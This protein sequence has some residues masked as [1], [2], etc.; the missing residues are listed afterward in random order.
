[1]L[2]T[3][4]LV[5]PS[6]SQ[7]DVEMSSPFFMEGRLY[8]ACFAFD[9]SLPRN[10]Q[11][12]VL[13]CLDAE[14]GRILWRELVC[15]G[16][17]SS[18]LGF[19]RDGKPHVSIAARRG[20]LQCYDVSGESPRRAWSFQMPH[21]TL[22]SPVVADCDGRTLLF[23][24]SKYG[25]LIALDAATGKEVWQK[26]AGNWFDN[27]ACVGDVGGRKLVFAGSH[28]YNLYALDARD[29]AL[30]WKKAL[31]GEIH[32]AP[33]LLPFADRAAVAVAA[34]D[35]HLYVLD[36]ATGESRI[37]YFTGNPIWDKL[38][39]GETLWGSPSAIVAGRQTALVYG[40]FN[41]VVYTIPVEKECSL[42]ASPRSSA[43]LWKSLLF[44]AVLFCGLVVPLVV[45]F[46]PARSATTVSSPAT[47]R[48]NRS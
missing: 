41:N 9:K 18:P 17:T 43:S 44:V 29:G 37:S 38:V 28:D 36:A 22:G 21:E 5:P 33:C 16:P 19:K 35:N 7:G 8:I 40:S 42:T 2:W 46:T 15:D 3:S 24:G 39:K 47:T 10:S 25:N 45:R 23:L 12:G 48:A 34:L 31:G 4:E 1:M 27:G 30:V 6:N 26:M 11:R 32:S 13:Y 14:N 20:L